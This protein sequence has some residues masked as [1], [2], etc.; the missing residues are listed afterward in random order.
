[1]LKISVLGLNQKSISFI[2][3]IKNLGIEEIFGYDFD[4]D[5]LKQ[6]IEKK[7]INNSRFDS[8]EDVVRNKDIIIIAVPIKK[9][10]FI[11]GKILPFIG[12]ETVITDLNTAKKEIFYKTAKSLAHKQIN[13]IPSTPLFNLENNKEN[14]FQNNKVLITIDL[15]SKLNLVN[16]LAQFWKSLGMDAENINVDDHD[17]I[18]SNVLHLPFIFSCIYNKYLE[19][20]HDK[21]NKIYLSSLITKEI[22]QDIVL[23]KDNIISSMSEAI[24]GLNILLKNIN[25][26][27]LE[28]VLKD[29]EET[30]KKE[31]EIA[32]IFN[33]DVKDDNKILNI[34]KSVNEK[35]YLKALLYIVLFQYIDKFYYS[36]INSDF[37]EL[38]V[39]KL[40]KN[41]EKVLEKN[42]SEIMNF[43]EYFLNEI[44]K[45]KNIIKT[46]KEINLPEEIKVFLNL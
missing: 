37:L 11:L 2:T 20:N 5:L 3:K 42:K 24:D 15:R 29:I 9:Y 18:C 17:I 21:G 33:L 30:I 7:L 25:Y 19:N 14:I 23:N 22:E 44:S 28:P 13:F 10:E 4:T 39:L 45:F 35:D 34:F 31:K 1:M 27:K 8:L 32:E 40:G 6:A 41:H 16:K 46:T 12:Q 43:L 36:Y 38:F 26:N